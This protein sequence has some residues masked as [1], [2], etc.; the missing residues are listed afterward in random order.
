MITFIAMAACGAVIAG[1][2]TAA[3]RM[4]AAPADRP[5]RQET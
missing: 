3:A 2:L 4:L 1:C 5:P